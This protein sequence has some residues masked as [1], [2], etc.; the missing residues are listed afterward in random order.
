MVLKKNPVDDSKQ[1]LT[2][3][4]DYCYPDIHDITIGVD[5][6][7]DYIQEFRFLVGYENILK[8]TK[9]KYVRIV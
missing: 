8:K 9:E 3:R 4:G 6:I 1:M 5:Y 2:C 7:E